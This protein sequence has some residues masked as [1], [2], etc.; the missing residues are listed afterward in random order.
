MLTGRNGQRNDFLEMPRPNPSSAVG[1]VLW[2]FV[3]VGCSSPDSAPLPELPELAEAALERFAPEVSRQILQAY[4]RAVEQP[5]DPQACGRLGM[6]L[7]AYDQLESAADCYQRARRLDPDSFRWAYYLG[8][9]QIRLGRHETGILA[10]HEALRLDP[11]FLPA[12]LL[13][14][15]ALSAAG[16]WDESR[17][18]YSQILQEHPRLPL[19]HYGLGQVYTAQGHTAQALQSYRHACELSPEFAA[20]HYAL[21]LA[22]RDAG[23]GPEARRHF[24]AYRRYRGTR[25]SLEDPLLQEVESLQRGAVHHFQQAQREERRRRLEEATREYERALELDPNLTQAHVNLISLYASLGRPEKGREHYQACIQKNPYLAEAHYNYGVL[26]SLEGR[27][28]EATQAF[29]KAVEI[30]PYYPDAHN[31]LANMKEQ[32]GDLGGAEIH[33]RAALRDHPGHRLARFGLGRVLSQSGRPREAIPHLRQ[34]LE[35]EDERT[36]MILYVLADAYLR[37]GQARQ[38]LQ[39]ARTALAKAEAQGWEELAEAIETDLQKLEA[40]FE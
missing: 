20:A 15:E 27:H 32:A 2:T 34:A 4:R 22:C 6:V 9:V 12:R 37:A 13:L 21:A 17:R 8:V 28:R 5:Q 10:L 7:H 36:P 38:A 16:R 23:R 26:L 33:Y 18:L 35:E 25:P 3:F 30:N 31:N 24:E 39:T 1:A 29:E 40:Q 19:A 14:A 11:D